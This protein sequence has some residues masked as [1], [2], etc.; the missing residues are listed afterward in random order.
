MN[1][2]LVSV[3]IPT[4][5]RLHTLKRALDS[6]IDQDYRPIEIIIVDDCSTD[7]TWEILKNFNSEDIYINYI[8]NEVNLWPSLSRNVAFALSQWEYIAFLDSDDEWVATNKLS[9]QID[10]LSHNMDYWF[11]ATRWQL[12]NL[13]ENNLQYE[14]IFET[15][16]EFRK[17]ALCYYPAH[18]SSWLIRKS[19]IEEVGWFSFRR[20][21]DYEFLLKIGTITKFYC[22]PTITEKYNN[23]PSGVHQKNVI[24]NWFWALVVCV[25][26]R[27]SYPYF[28]RAFSNRVFRWFKKWLYSLFK[29]VQFRN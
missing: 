10:F 27:N 2:N 29:I 19:I 3:V 6:V 24:K 23:L 28:F 15:D 8:Y 26:Y 7:W 4:Y 1:K 11:V 22:L 17:I 12:Q 21:G 25:K 14:Y 13:S 9:L 5:N 16:E 18:T 20:A